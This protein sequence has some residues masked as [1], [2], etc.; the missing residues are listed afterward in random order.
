MVTVRKFESTSGVFYAYKISAESTSS[1]Q[2]LN[3]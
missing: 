1:S 3:K 2:K